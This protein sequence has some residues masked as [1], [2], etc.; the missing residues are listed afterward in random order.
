MSSA[1]QAREKRRQTRGDAYLTRPADAPANAPLPRYGW[2][3]QHALYA[4]LAVVLK[5]MF[6]LKPAELATKS[7]GWLLTHAGITR[8]AQATAKFTH[9][10]LAMPRRTVGHCLDALEEKQFIA[11]WEDSRPR[12]SPFGTSWRLRRFDE[13]LQRWADDPNIGTVG[14]RA[15]YVAGKARRHFTQS[16]LVSWNLNHAAAAQNPAA[17]AAAIDIDE[18]QAATAAP[19]LTRQELLEADVEVVHR[20]ILAE[21][22]DATP[23]HAATLLAQARAIE[24]TI[25]ADSVGQLVRKMAVDRYEK[26]RAKRDPR[27][28]LTLGWFTTG[29]EAAVHQWKFNRDAAAAATRRA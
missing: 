6:S 29:M 17:H 3:V 12:T 27:P 24:P 26:A 10:G 20:A 11:R 23:A 21:Q 8:I 15:F 7:Q 14:K 9:D 28:V 19:K 1:A 13:I 4:S 22:V 2:L 25:P 5:A 18:P 16:E